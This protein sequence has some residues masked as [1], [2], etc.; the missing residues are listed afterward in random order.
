MYYNEANKTM[1][2]LSLVVNMYCNDNNNVRCAKVKFILKEYKAEP[3]FKTR[4]T[5]V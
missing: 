1:I 3:V 5:T 4:I 2:S